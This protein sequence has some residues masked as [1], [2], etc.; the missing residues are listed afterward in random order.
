[1]L[2]KGSGGIKC[3]ISLKTLGVAERGAAVYVH[4]LHE[5]ARILKVTYN[6]LLLSEASGLQ[7]PGPNTSV[8]RLFQ[9]PQP[10]TDFV[11][12]ETEVSGMVAR[13]RSE[14]CRVG[15]SALRGMGGVGKT[16]V[17]VY[18][19][20]LVKDRFPDAHLFLDLLG[21]SER[22]M[23]AFEVMAQIIRDFHPEVLKLPET[24]A[25]L[26]S[27]YRSTLAGKQALIVLDNAAG[28]VQVKNLVT[29]E[30]TGFIITSRKALALDG[31]ASVQIDVFSPEKS[32]AFLRGIVGSKG[33]DDELRT[34]TELCGYLPLALR[35]AGDF[36]RTKTDW[37]VNR[38]IEAL[39]KE[40][41]RWLKVGDDPQK[42]VEAVLK[43]SSA[44]LVRDDPDLAVRW[45]SIADWQSDFDIDTA[46]EVWELDTNDD[47]LDDLSE[48]VRRSL[49][50]FDE[51][52]FR[53]RLHDLMKPIAAGLFG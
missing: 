27:M 50:L 7:N 1:M 17:A 20:H 39:N 48:L 3:P 23:T 5:L 44:Q 25:E 35:V 21:V 32:L 16:T 11:S 29:G 49:V 37:T 45:H 22:P 8:G 18:V 9:L 12:R 6:E 46:A 28:E 47:V 31:V 34:V 41:L 53:Y 42:D 26:L 13:L 2:I 30:K 33:S 4:T 40:R 51:R 19:A 36:L 43:L 38:Y 52:S 14:G 15:L 10:L 24:E